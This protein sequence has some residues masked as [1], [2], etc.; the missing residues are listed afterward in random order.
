M[1]TYLV[2]NTNIDCPVSSTETFSIMG[3]RVIYFATLD[4]NTHNSGL[5]AILSSV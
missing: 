5:H 3:K 2:V 1:I 4:R